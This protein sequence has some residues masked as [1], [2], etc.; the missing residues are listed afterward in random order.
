MYMTSYWMQYF[1]ETCY[2]QHCDI[3]AVAKA[4][5]KRLEMEFPSEANKE[6]R[7]KLENYA[8]QGYANMTI[9]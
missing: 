4:A 7:Q 6:D 5:C 2:Y 8:I 1:F 9:Y 3:T